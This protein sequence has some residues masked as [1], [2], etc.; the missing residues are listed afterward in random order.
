MQAIRNTIAALALAAGTL[1]AQAAP[2]PGFALFDTQV[3]FY[4]NDFAHF[5]LHDEHAYMG[6]AVMT[7]R[8]AEHPT[9][10]RRVFAD[11]KAEGVGAGVGIQYG[12]AYGGDNRYLLSVASRFP[13]RVRP[14]VILNPEAP[15]AAAELV[16]L[17]REHGVAG[18]RKLGHRAPDGGYPWLRTPGMLALWQAADEHGLVVELMPYPRTPDPRFLHDIGELAARYPHAKIVLDH[19]AW[20]MA[21]P[22]PDFGIGAPFEALAAARNVYW[23]FTT[24]N[25]EHAQ[26]QPEAMQHL[27]QRAVQVFGADHVMWGSDMGNTMLPYRRMVQAALVATGSLDAAQRRAVLRTTGEA[28]YAAP[29]P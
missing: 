18:F 13:A 7:R 15:G 24:E 26:F 21:G 27:V 12:A 23:K 1:A 8:A 11:W 29:R 19:L 6:Q 9:L 17:A 20:A 10:P 22:A 25:L 16:R 14:V 28:V 5:P 3:H 4:S 2:A